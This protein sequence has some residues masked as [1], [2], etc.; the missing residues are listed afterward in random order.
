MRTENTYVHGQD[1]LRILPRDLW[2]ASFVVAKL[3]RALGD[4]ISLQRTSGDSDN[5]DNF[6]L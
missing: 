1:A 4:E 5:E 2:S 3:V 6:T